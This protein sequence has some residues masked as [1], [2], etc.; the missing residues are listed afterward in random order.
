MNPFSHLAT[1]PRYPATRVMDKSERSVLRLPC[2][3]FLE[4]CYSLGFGTTA[5]SGDS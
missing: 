1:L 5:A 2:T 3:H 4:L